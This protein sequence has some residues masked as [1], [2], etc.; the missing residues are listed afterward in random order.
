MAPE[1]EEQQEVARDSL[2]TRRTPL[3][4]SVCQAVQRQQ[5]Q[6]QVHRVETADGYRLSLHRIPAP[7]NRRCPQQLRPFLLMH[8]LLGSAGDF[9]SGGRGRSLALELH[10]RCFDVW[11]ANARGTTH[12]RGHRTLQTS[13]ARFWQFSWHEIGIYDLPAI[14]DYVLA[15]TNRRQLHYVGHSQGTTVLLVLLSQRPEYNAR[16]A[17]AAL[18]APVAFLQH[19]SSPPLRLL[20][21]DSSMA[22]LLLN[23][24]GLHEL[25]PATALTQVGG[26]FFCTASRPTYALCTLFTSLYVG[27]S[28]YPLDRSILPRI[29]ET[30]PAGISRGQLQHFGQL[31]NSGKFQQYDYRSPRLNTLRYGRTT[32]PSYQLANVRLQLQIFHGSRDALS[33]LADVQRLVRELRNSATQMYQVP[34]YNNIDFLFA[35]SAPQVVF[36]RIIQQA[37]QLDMALAAL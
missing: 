32:P 2:C 26:Q 31:I 29:L 18:M 35:S 13:D 36:Q 19:L 5:L 12:S 21:R 27:F 11:L 14:V 9:V 24:L 1:E 37:W 4:D 17:N 10:A 15:R 16:F 30:T 8:G 7:Q 33:S 25:L 34:G 20:A 22:T 3:I 28:D 23:K 6:C